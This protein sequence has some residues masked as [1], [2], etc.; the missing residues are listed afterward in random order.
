MQKEQENRVKL[1]LQVTE[2]EEK[3]DTLNQDLTVAREKEVKLQD[4][5]EGEREAKMVSA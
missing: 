3:V 4:D 2:L 5:L 1:E